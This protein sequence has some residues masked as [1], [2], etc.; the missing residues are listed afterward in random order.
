[1]KL[2]TIEGMDYVGKTTLQQNIVPK[3]KEALK[4]KFEDVIPIKF[5]YY[6]SQTGRMIKDYLNDKSNVENN[7]YDFSYITT[8]YTLNRIEFFRD[9]P[10][11]LKRNVLLIADRYTISNIIH[12]LPRR[13]KERKYL[14]NM[15]GAEGFIRARI[16]D[17]IELEACDKYLPIPKLCFYMMPES[18]DFLLKCKASRNDEPDKLETDERLFETYDLYTSDDIIG[19]IASRYAYFDSII[20]PIWVSD[21]VRKTMVDRTVEII[22][23]I[24]NDPYYS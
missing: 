10:D 3:L 9:N 13:L 5:P 24:L 7:K 19:M 18:F 14:L 22:V 4:D 17:M 21:E 2:I 20:A 6:D 11:L 16:D 1:M 12:H 8:L 15:K 23:E